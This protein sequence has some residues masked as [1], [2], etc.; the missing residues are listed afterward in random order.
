MGKIYAESITNEAI[1]QLSIGAFPGEIVVVDT[2]EAA[3]AACEYLSRFPLIGFD[4]E[5]RPSFTKGHFNKVAL[6]QLSADDKAF[7]FRLNLIGLPE[8][9]QRVLSSDRIAK[10][11]VAVYEDVRMLRSWH[12]FPPKKFV[13]LQNIA[14]RYG[15]TDKSL[16]KLAAITLNIRI[17]INIF[18]EAYQSRFIIISE[19]DVHANDSSRIAVIQS[20]A[21]ASEFIAIEDTSIS[22][23]NIVSKVNKVG[24]CI[25]RNKC[26]A[27]AEV[28]FQ[29]DDSVII[30]IFEV[31]AL[32]V[33]EEAVTSYCAIN[34]IVD[35]DAVASQVIQGSFNWT[36]SE[37]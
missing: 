33:A 7:L 27:V 3:E 28:E 36:I 9:V 17:N 26:Y 5:T 34:N 31:V 22:M 12:R 29:I 25:S 35:F 19:E 32:V 24:E 10:V 4:T 1:N 2:P 23:L 16:R 15:I 13:E 30:I 18:I 37:N 8:S 6:L 21:I 11:G 20:V 14:P